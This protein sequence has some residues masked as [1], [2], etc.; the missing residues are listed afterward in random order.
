MVPLLHQHGST[1]SYESTRMMLLV[2]Y[3]IIYGSHTVAPTPGLPF[4][5]HVALATD[6]LYL[7]GRCTGVKGVFPGHS[8]IRRVVL[9]VYR[10]FRYDTGVQA[11]SWMFSMLDRCATLWPY[12]MRGLLQLPVDLKLHILATANEVFMRVPRASPPPTYRRILAC[13]WWAQGRFVSTLMWYCTIVCLCE[14]DTSVRLPP[15]VQFMEVATLQLLVLN[16]LWSDVWRRLSPFNRA[17]LA[18][19]IGA[20]GSVVQDGMEVDVDVDVDVDVS[21]AQPMLFTDITLNTADGGTRIVHLVPVRALFILLEVACTDPQKAVRLLCTSLLSCVRPHPLLVQISEGISSPLATADAHLFSG[22]T[23]DAHPRPYSTDDIETCRELAQLKT[24][25]IDLPRPSYPILP[26]SFLPQRSHR[27]RVPAFAR[28]TMIWQHS[29]LVWFTAGTSRDFLPGIV[30]HLPAFFTTLPDR[31]WEWCSIEDCQRE[32][33][34]VP[35][36][37]LHVFSCSAEVD[38]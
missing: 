28:D 2:N 5:P 9:T 14:F 12:V 22:T 19:E 13:P 27:P 23:S 36:H 21:P 15:W 10:H 35:G 34:R 30:N 31:H 4:L 29:A 33:R 32:R 8:L 18:S 6:M 26:Y 20:S 17:R 7:W 38:I 25:M 24:A 11:E 1:H 16:R 3:G 37:R